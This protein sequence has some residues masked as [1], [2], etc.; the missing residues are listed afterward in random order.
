MAQRSVH[1]GRNVL[2][3]IKPVLFVEVMERFM[4]TNALLKD[5][6]VRRRVASQ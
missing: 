6:S 2:L 4:K 3:E 5:M 1:A